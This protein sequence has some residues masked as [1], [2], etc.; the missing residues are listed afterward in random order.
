MHSFVFPHQYEILFFLLI[1]DNDKQK[2]L[3][4]LNPRSSINRDVEILM[5]LFVIY[6]LPLL[7]FLCL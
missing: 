1:F 2:E 7:I 5:Y 4:I 6:V 3:V